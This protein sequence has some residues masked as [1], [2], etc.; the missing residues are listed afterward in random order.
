MNLLVMQI[1]PL[2]YHFIS[3][4]SKYPP[5]QPVL[6]GKNWKIEIDNNLK[7]EIE[8]NGKN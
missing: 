3:L 8:K 5:Q 1:S 4:R 6:N 7:I 2:P